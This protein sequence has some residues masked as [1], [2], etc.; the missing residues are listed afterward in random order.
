MGKADKNRAKEV[1]AQQGQ[2]GQEAIT[3]V[4]QQNQNLQNQISPQYQAATAQNQQNYADIMGTYNQFLKS[5]PD[6][7]SLYSQF[8]GIPTGTTTTD[9]TGMHPVDALLSKYGKTDTGPGS[10]FT[11]AN[12]W[13]QKYDSTGDKYYLERLE[14]DLQGKGIDN[15]GSG[16]PSLSGLDMGALG[17]AIA[18]YKNFAQTGGFSPEDIQSIRARSVAPIRSI[19][20]NA[21]REIQRQ[22]A[23]RGTGYS[24]NTTAALAKSVRDA[25]YA[26]GDITTNAEASLA[27][28]Q[29]QGKLY[30]LGGLSS[31]GLGAYGLGLQG[32]GQDLA[33]QLGLRGQNLSAI[34]GAG[35]QQLGA[36]GGMGNLYGTTPGL[37]N[38]FGQQVLQAGQQGISVAGLQGQFSQNQIENAM[39][40]GQMKGIPW[41]EILA[42]TAGAI[43]IGAT[44][45]AAAPYVVPAV[46]GMYK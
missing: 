32:R 11:D 20:D 33:Q 34:Q 17:P 4:Q 44:G 24:P 25:A 39:R 38:M 23:I 40:I 18:G 31:T 21:R 45:G 19:A 46:A 41:K 7:G 28:L 2:I 14:S 27:Q 22:A 37:S 35:Q 36:M 42:T 10:G 3:N 29:Q 5:Q 13:K 15:G 12:Y 1:M 26:T 30:G 8:L 16:G 9:T 43:A 6:I